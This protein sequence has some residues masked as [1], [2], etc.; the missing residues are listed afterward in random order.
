MNPEACSRLESARLQ[1]TAS[2]CL[3]FSSGAWVSGTF[4]SR[5]ACSSA[6]AASLSRRRLAAV[7]GLHTVSTRP[8]TTPKKASTLPSTYSFTSFRLGFWAIISLAS[9]ISSCTVS[10]SGAGMTC[11]RSGAGKGPVQPRKDGH[12]LPEHPSLGRPAGRGTRPGPRPTALCPAGLTLEAQ[13]EREAARAGG[14]GAAAVSASGVRPASALSSSS[15]AAA[16]PGGDSAAGTLAASRGRLYL[17]SETRLSVSQG[18]GP[19]Q[20]LPEEGGVFLGLRAN[21]TFSNH[22]TSSCRVY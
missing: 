15:A 14:G 19:A 10:I 3:P 16:L 13:R 6:T 11:G 12:G 2:C 17:S 18:P 21:F 7:K 5:A 8:I 22:R 4:R 9:G 20:F 1:R